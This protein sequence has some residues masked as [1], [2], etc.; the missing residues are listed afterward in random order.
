M[1]MRWPLRVQTVESISRTPA[2][3]A[4]KAS[5]IFGGNYADETDVQ[6]EAGVQRRIDVRYRSFF[7]RLAFLPNYPTFSMDADRSGMVVFMLV[8][9]TRLFGG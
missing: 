2:S 9:L 4:T 7:K 6:A 8:C 3:R 5:P 1:K